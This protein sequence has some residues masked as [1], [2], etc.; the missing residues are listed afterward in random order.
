[1]ALLATPPT[2]AEAD[3]LFTEGL[4]LYH[5]GDYRGAAERLE[6]VLVIGEAHFGKEH[7]ALARV[8]NALGL[9]LTYTGNYK[10][11]RR[12][13][14]RALKLGESP[15]TLNNLGFALKKMGDYKA[16]RPVYERALVLMK[17]VAGP[18]HP[19]VGVLTDNLASLLVELADYDEARRLYESANALFVKV[20][21]PEHATV[22]TNLNNQGVL[23]KQIGDHDGAIAAY[24]RVL[25][26]WE[27]AL[28]ADHPNVG[29]TLDNLATSYSDKG[30]YAEAIPLFER[31]LAIQQKRLGAEHESLA[32]TLNNMGWAQLR[33]G[34]R[35]QA[36]ITLKR[37]VAITRKALG[38]DHIQT[39]VALS[40]LADAHLFA[41]EHKKAGRLF[42]Q[43]KRILVKALGP[44]HP[45]VA[46]RLKGLAEVALAGGRRKE[47]RTHALESL[48]I[49]E[50]AVSA[51][52]WST[53]ERERLAVV[54]GHRGKVDLLLAVLDDP[55]VA[56]NVVL[57]WKAAVLSSRI[58]Q[59][60]QLRRHADPSVHAQLEALA[61]VRTRLA[62][63]TVAV[64]APAQRQAVAARLTALTSEKERL[65]RELS[66][67]SDRFRQA[68]DRSRAKARDI[69]AGLA[70][71]A[72]I[73]DYVRYYRGV[74]PHFTAFVLRAGQCD[75]PIRVALGPAKTIDDAVEGFRKA[76]YDEL[77]VEE[78][79]E[80]ARV[81]RRAIW[82]KVSPH[83]AGRRYVWVVPDGAVNGIPFAAFPRGDEETL[84]EDTRYLVERYTFSYLATARDALRHS[85]PALA[86]AN[87]GRRLVVG[88]VTYEPAGAVQVAD[89]G[90]V[91][92]RGAG[93]GLADKL[94]Y[95]Y[96]PASRT[97]ADT[98][99]KA[100]GDKTQVMQGAAATESA[101]RAAL[102]KSSIAHL[103][104]HGYFAGQCAER[105]GGMN[106]LVLSG[107]ALAGA[108][109]E[110]STRTAGGSDGILTA[111]EVAGLELSGLQLMILSACETGLGDVRSGQGVLGLRW[112]FSVAGARAL[113]MSLWKVP[114]EETRHLMEHFYVAVAA[115][116]Q[117]DKA[118]AL[119]AAQLAL[120]KRLR[121]EGEANPWAWAAF[122]VSGR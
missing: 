83:L 50:K 13:L 76:I 33:A 97:E 11:G 80:A 77:L 6:K 56:Y 5:K 68:G 1:M 106:P 110:R 118:V 58:E 81:A 4:A 26:I 107:V 49:A 65:E 28:G 104:T 17:R 29:V 105:F 85:T 41:G 31:S 82:D 86:K 37:S 23:L 96:L 42:K 63:L 38:A 117:A 111:E 51:L 34:M 14:E 3:A 91:K 90:A 122:I 78:V 25:K 47:A 40:N 70:Q 69:C 9:S 48:R 22:A 79:I 94:A 100:L 45:F 95:A 64:P 109:A 2:M 101:I 27:K 12:M 46:E 103:A 7:R 39:A 99:A 57:R 62:T 108:N 55:A 32:L 24:R 15:S 54:A 67:R 61:S 84:P 87:A 119:R 74:N 30:R 98:V 72:A 93:C 116:P 44:D 18:E 35:D 10:R 21:G 115:N 92:T 20:N 60:D 112:A 8:L 19:Q 36:R 102:Q 88:G 121:R 114:D 16:A 43:S 53:S 59:R 75:A 66:R 52:L 89:A 71:G 73:V 120:L 113:V